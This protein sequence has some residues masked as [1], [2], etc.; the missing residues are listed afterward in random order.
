[1]KD[2]EE[3]NESDIYATLGITFGAMGFAGIGFGVLGLVFSILSF[4]K[5]DDRKL[6]IIAFI[7]STITT[8]IPFYSSKRQLSLRIDDQQ[9]SCGYVSSIMPCMFQ[10]YR[11]IE[12]TMDY[13]SRAG[14]S[15]R[16]MCSCFSVKIFNEAL[17]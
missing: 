14:N 12:A 5:G 17:L 2:T 7:I 16:I 6:P 4:N 11:T 1:M 13:Q 3:E 15:V 8:A 10:R 9:F